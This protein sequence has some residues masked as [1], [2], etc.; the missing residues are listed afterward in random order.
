M[1]NGG[2]KST[3]KNMKYGLALGGGGAKGFALIGALKFLEE[4]GFNPNI[5]SG[6]SIGAIIGAML[7]KGF[8]A[9]EIFEEG[10]KISISKI[11]ELDIPLKGLS[12]KGKF[13]TVFRKYLMGDIEDLKTK[14][15]AVATNIQTGMPHFFE[16]GNLLDTVSA[17]CSIPGFFTPEIIDGITF[18][19]GGLT[20]MTPVNILR[21]KGVKKIISIS[22]LHFDYELIKPNLL[23]ND[24]V[25]DTI[26]IAEDSLTR[27]EER[28]SDIA[29]R[30]PTG[31]YAALSTK[32]PMEL[33]NLGYNAAKKHSKK[34]KK[35]LQR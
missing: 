18:V 7:A 1:K 33:F 11:F 29:I 5:I 8:S 15:I 9:D 34:I 14:F 21:D 23:I 6:T 10:K 16:K 3:N 24:I 32:N 17:S 31:K 12:K 4:F 28:N 2:K 35:L 27:L 30:I 26:R 22:L 20:S 19:D 13:K 25:R